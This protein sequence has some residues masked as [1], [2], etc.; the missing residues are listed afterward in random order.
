M[1]DTSLVG[2]RGG[3]VERIGRI[4]QEDVVGRD[5]GA[6]RILAEEGQ[7]RNRFPR[8]A[9][10]A[11]GRRPGLREREVRLLQTELVGRITVEPDMLDAQAANQRE[12]ARELQPVL[13]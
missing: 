6:G 11:R 1:L 4:E 2:A 8:V 12:A 9:D 5:V 3:Q 10:T 7:A 13:E